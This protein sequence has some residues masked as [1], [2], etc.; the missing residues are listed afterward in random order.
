MLVNNSKASYFIL[1]VI[2]FSVIADTIPYMLLYIIYS[3]YKGGINVSS[4]SDRILARR[5]ELGLSQTDLA[6]RAGLQP[7]AISQ[8]ESGTRNPSYE[9]LIKLSNVLNVTIDYL[10]SGKEVS[11]GTIN[12][13][14]TKLLLKI[15]QNLSIKDRDKLLEYAVFLSSDYINNVSL[16]VEA[17][18]ADYA[19]KNYWNNTLPV[20]VY[21]VAKKIKISIYEDELDEECEGKLINGK[22]KIIILNSRIQNRQRKKFTISILI[23]HALI[24]WHIK[25]SYNVRKIGSSTLLTEDIQEMEAHDFAAKLIMPQA[26][27][28]KDFIKIRA[29]I[30]SLKKLAV[31]KYDVSLF[32]LANRLV[33]YAKDKYAV[34]QS[35]NLKVIKTFQGNRP[36]VE[37]IDHKS[38]AATFF[39]NPSIMEDIRHGEVPAKY[40]F[41]DAEDD[42]VIYEE[43]IY[44]P[45][46]DKVLTLLIQ[47]KRN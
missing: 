2:G 34:I 7:P 22:D 12:D 19:L 4:I 20:D 18:F 23:G 31:E 33:D 29:S 5:E 41:L 44:N 3:R 8:Y 10:I 43:C 27:L 14:T 15:T 9:A 45:E 42:E 37:T 28:V 13:K 21:E 30:E 39:E 32:A 11:I 16:S 47:E 35:E 40:W 26:Y 46:Y 36:L 6:K 17:D 38:I 1:I 24:P 25:P